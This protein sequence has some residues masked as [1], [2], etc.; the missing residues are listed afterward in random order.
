MKKTG[1][2]KEDENQSH[3]SQMMAVEEAEYAMLE[4]SAARIEAV[5]VAES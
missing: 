3:V 5:E 1:F 2:M 4:A